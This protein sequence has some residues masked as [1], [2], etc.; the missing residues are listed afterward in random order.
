M[1]NKEK[2][3][4]INFFVLGAAKCG[5]SS[6]YNYLSQHPDIYMSMP[7]EPIFFEA[8][9]HKGTEYYFKTYFTGRKSEY[10]L[11]ESRHRNLYLPYIPSRIAET[12]PNAKLIVILRNPIDR[13]YS[14]YFHRRAHGYEN[15]SFEDAIELDSQRINK[16]MLINTEEE[17]EKYV[18][19]LKNNTSLYIR[20]Y[21]DSGYYSEQIERYLKYFQKD[22]MYI[23]FIDEF[24][25]EPR[26][27]YIKLL[28]FLG[29]G[30]CP[31]GIKFEVI[32]KK[33]SKLYMSVH[34]GLTGNQK[35]RALLNFFL[36]DQIKDSVQNL[37][38][39][40]EHQ[41][42]K[43]KEIKKETRIWLSLHYKPYNKRLEEITG[44]DLSHWDEKK[45]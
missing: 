36:T 23:T 40:F 24:K 6:V 20:T 30:T 45:C 8:E 44:R 7:K 9:Y 19:A 33:K 42:F 32:N 16:G 43:K 29:I 11:G 17:I 28:N 35:L 5:T 41:L 22:Q 25:K 1:H 4:P 12:F 31:D 26:K 13:A 39:L 27:E 34:K 37:A 15:L 3:L 10:F 14:H 38:S 2:T 18:K 21:L